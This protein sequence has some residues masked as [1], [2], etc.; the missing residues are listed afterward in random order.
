MVE[1]ILF[2]GSFCAIFWL[3]ERGL[4]PGLTLSN[5]YI[6][7]DEGQHVEGAQMIHEL[8]LEK[9]DQKTVHAIVREAVAI[10][11]EFIC[12]S[13]PCKLIGIN[14]KTMSEYIKYV[15][16]RFLKQFGYDIL[17]PNVTQPFPFMDRICLDGKANFFEV[18]SSQYNKLAP[19]TAGQNGDPYAD[20]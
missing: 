18:R 17:Y 9:A 11:I 5:E 2:S 12:D 20:I 3:K 14:S 8:L 4:M 1:G 15:A 19:S 7:R 6:S 13:L 10:E 16:N